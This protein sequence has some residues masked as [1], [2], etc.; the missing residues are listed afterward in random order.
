MCVLADANGDSLRAESTEAA[1]TACLDD[2]IA[3]LEARP[4]KLTRDEERHWCSAPRKHNRERGRAEMR[5]RSR[6]PEAPAR[7]DIAQRDAHVRGGRGVDELGSRLH[8]GPRQEDAA[9]RIRPGSLS[10]TVIRDQLR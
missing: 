10:S 1:R 6:E 5:A 7:S 8:R 3:E 2:G 9:R 4:S